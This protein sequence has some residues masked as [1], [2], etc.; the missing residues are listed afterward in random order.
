[1]SERMC[2][3]AG[4][5]HYR[6]SR[7][8]DVPTLKRMTRSLAHRGPNGEGFLTDGPVGL[9]NRRLAIV[10]LS[11]TGHQPMQT[12]DG[13]AT[14]TYNGEFY[15][16]Q[17]FRSKLEAHGTQFRGSSD[18]ETLLYALATYGPCVLTN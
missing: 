18:S 3:I 6:D 8:V 12:A 2:G 5:F 9:G 11:A 14:L 7:P 17:T 4:I 1:T 15:N 13:S 10:D 16:H